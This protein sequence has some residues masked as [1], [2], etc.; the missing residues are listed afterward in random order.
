MFPD[1]LLYGNDGSCSFVPR[2]LLNELE[3][4]YQIVNLQYEA[5]KMEAADGS[6]SNEEYKRIN[7]SGYIPALGIGATAITELPAICAFIARLASERGLLGTNP[8]GQ[9][10]VDEWMAWLSGTLHGYCFA[11]MWAPR[12]FTEDQDAVESIRE[13][14]QKVVLECYERIECSMSG[15]SAVGDSLTVVDFALYMFGRWGTLRIGLAKDHMQNNY[16]KYTQLMREM[17]SRAR[18]RRTLDEHSLAVVFGRGGE[19]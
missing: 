1:I 8:I 11:M 9:A 15:G 17:E 12:R 14:G 7:P 10:K 6:L 5:G 18:V 13:Q 2:A 16:P 19:V 4:P 3:I